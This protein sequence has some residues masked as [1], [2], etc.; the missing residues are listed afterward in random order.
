MLHDINVGY[1]INLVLYSIP[2]IG[3][4]IYLDCMK[5]HSITICGGGGVSKISLCITRGGG[6]L[7]GVNFV[8]RDKWTAPYLKT[9]KWIN[10]GKSPNLPH[11]PPHT[12]VPV[13]VK[14]SK[15]QK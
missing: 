5:Y 11:L 8:S 10:F 2:L 13:G 4:V 6:G 1:F 12:D 14:P 15:H 9:K 3:C 7:E